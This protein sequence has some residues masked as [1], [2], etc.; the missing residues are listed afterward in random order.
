VGENENAESAIRRFRKAVMSSGHIQE[1]REL[2]REDARTRGRDDDDDAR[3]ENRVIIYHP[4]RRRAE[5]NAKGECRRTRRDTTNALTDR[6]RY[7]FIRR[8]DPPP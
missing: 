7:V 1:V 8:A 3:G 5:E 4:L 6:T 2:A